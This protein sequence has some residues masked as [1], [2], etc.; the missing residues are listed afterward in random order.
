[1]PIKFFLVTGAL[2]FL[3]N[4]QILH[5]LDGSTFINTSEQDTTGEVL[6]LDPILLTMD[7]STGPIEYVELEYPS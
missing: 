1:M 5:L 2:E 6:Y 3:E 4:R 7:D